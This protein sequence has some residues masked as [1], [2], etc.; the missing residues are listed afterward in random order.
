M[1][2]QSYEPPLFLIIGWSEAEYPETGRQSL[3]ALVTHLR[4]EPGIRGC[5]AALPEERRARQ[6][7]LSF[8]GSVKRGTGALTSTLVRASALSWDDLDASTSAGLDEL[9]ILQD[10]AEPAPAIEVVRK[11][12]QRATAS[13]VGIRVWLEVP[14]PGFQKLTCAWKYGTYTTLPVELSP[15]RQPAF[16]GIS[17]TSARNDQQLACEWLRMT[18]TVSSAGEV[19]RCPA[20]LDGYHAR[21]GGPAKRGQADIGTHVSERRIAWMQAG[22][23]HPVCRSCH[24]LVRLAGPGDL[25]IP[26]QACGPIVAAAGYRDYVGTDASALSPHERARAIEA[27][28]DRIHGP[29]GPE[30][31]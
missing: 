12:Q 18:V 7:L 21:D 16:N 26:A 1:P 24:R 27:F 25:E 2:Q 31:P 9:I 10:T 28:V 23:S 29:G 20:Y 5:L 14:E 15:F 4:D 11:Y 8:L 3:V 22:G 17:L 13:M 30:S 6:W 19:A